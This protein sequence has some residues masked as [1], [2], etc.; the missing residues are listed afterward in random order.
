MA[1]HY[2]RYTI[3]QLE[4]EEQLLKMKLKEAQENQETRFIAVHQ[5]KIEIVQSYMIDQSQFKVGDLF[6][7]NNDSEHLF[8]IDEMVGVIAWGYLTDLQTHEKNDPTDRIAKLLVLLGEK[9]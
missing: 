8:E 5:R 3:E 4:E 9:R 7:L 1:H 2:K 6:E